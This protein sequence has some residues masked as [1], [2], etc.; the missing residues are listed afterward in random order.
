[1]ENAMKG[2]VSDQQS[3]SIDT[4]SRV[5]SRKSEALPITIQSEARNLDQDYS[6]NSVS[7]MADENAQASDIGLPS[8]EGKCESTMHNLI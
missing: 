8:P 3:D 1:M 2:P 7:T 5:Y 4:N 6:L